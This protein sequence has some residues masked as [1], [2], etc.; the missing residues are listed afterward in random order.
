MATSL[1]ITTGALTSTLSS[2]DDVEAQNVLLN[3]ATAIGIAE[4]ATPQVKLNAV[5][6]HLAEYMQAA[7]RETWFR[8]ESA[9]LRAEAELQ[10]TWVKP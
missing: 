1:T 4:E 8:K 7:A 3:F 6:V 10:V 5:V 2:P 9:G